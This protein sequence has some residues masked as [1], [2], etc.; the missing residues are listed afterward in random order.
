MAIRIYNEIPDDLKDI[1]AINIFKS[2]LTKW[3]LSNCFYTINEFLNKKNI[4]R[5]IGINNNI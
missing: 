4:D 1:T 3:L 5:I 2:K